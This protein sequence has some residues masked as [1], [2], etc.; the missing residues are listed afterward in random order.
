[1][2]QRI[3][4]LTFIGSF[5]VQSM[6]A[7]ARRTLDFYLSDPNKYLK[8]TIELSVSYVDPVPSRAKID[9][10][11]FYRI[12]TTSES[13][14]K[15]LPLAVDSE[16]SKEFAIY[17]GTKPPDK[18][19][20]TPPLSA[21]FHFVDP[22]MERVIVTSGLWNAGIMEGSYFIDATTEG[23]LDTV[24]NWYPDK[25]SA[26]NSGKSINRVSASDVTE[27]DAT[28]K[29]ERLLAEKEAESKKKAKIVKKDITQLRD[30]KMCV[31]EFYL[32]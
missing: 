10:V 14:Y 21:R 30:K 20:D 2:I 12:Y 31:I 24:F 32:E 27:D 1:M 9:N 4:L 25:T 22:S 8:K 11:V 28:R 7:P 13:G 17:Y 5:V 16:K 18:L 19:K 15:S 23:Q 26:M 29:A 6:A 3:L